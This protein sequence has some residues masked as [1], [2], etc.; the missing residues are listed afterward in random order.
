MPER[1]PQPKPAF[2]DSTIARFN[3]P[4]TRV[5]AVQGL[6]VV[7]LTILACFGVFALGISV[8]WLVPL[9]LLLYSLVLSIDVSVEVTSTEIGVRPWLGQLAHLPWQ[10]RFPLWAL[11]GIQ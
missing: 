8:F 2:K 10:Q 7:L 5:I 1:L 6:I 3:I 9:A 11:V 4:Q